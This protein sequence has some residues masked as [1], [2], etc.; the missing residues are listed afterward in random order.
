VIRVLPADVLE[1]RPPPSREGGTDPLAWAESR[2][3]TPS[4][5]SALDTI[6]RGLLLEPADEVLITNTSGQTYVSPCVTCIVFNHC[7]PSRVLTERTRAIVAIHE[8]GYPH[9][10]LDELFRAA[11]ERGIPLI[12]DCAHSLD[13][14]VDETPLGSFGDFAIFSLPKVLPVRSG[15][16]VVGPAGALDDAP[17]DVEAEAAYRAHLPALLDYSRRRRANYEA[18][19]SRFPE[20]PLLLEAGS[21]VTPFYIGLLMPETP[22]IRA[23][24][25][26]VEWGS[27]LRDDL[28]LVTTNPFVEPGELVAALESAFAEMPA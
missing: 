8:F 23:R 7:Q 20:L 15:G 11:R 19:R 21:G 6:L 25:S 17:A 5:R 3:F 12:E 13:S 4:G 10:Q 14:T 1:R 28:L 18:V 2:R 16:I 26:A 27:T 9:P 24:S 22:A